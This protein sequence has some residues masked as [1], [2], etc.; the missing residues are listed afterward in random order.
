MEGTSF[1][2]SPSLL[3]PPLLPL[4]HLSDHQ[5]I[6]VSNKLTIWTQ[7]VGK[8]IPILS[9]NHLCFVGGVL[10][11]HRDHHVEKCIA[12]Q[13][14]ISDRRLCE[15]LALCDD[16]SSLIRNKE[17]VLCNEGAVSERNIVDGKVNCFI[18]IFM[19]SNI[20]QLNPGFWELI[21]CE[22]LLSVHKQEVGGFQCT[23]STKCNGTIA[24]PDAKITNP[25]LDEGSFQVWD[26]SQQPLMF[27][28]HGPGVIYEEH[29][30]RCILCL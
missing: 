27:Q 30:V 4:S 7:Q 8:T 19:K 9:Q 6:T 13:E 11:H 17:H 12:V 29:N 15:A 16:T 3:T 21:S 26:H 14:L 24:V 23:Y 2:S 5:T 20:L 22:A 25:S 10:V 28:L 18:S 1:N